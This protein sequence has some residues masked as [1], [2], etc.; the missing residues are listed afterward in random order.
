MEVPEGEDPPEVEEE[1][2]A[3]TG[4]DGDEPVATYGDDDVFA[5]WTTRLYNQTMGAYAVA[6][7]ASNRWP[8]A[9]AAI[10]KSGDKSSCIYIGHGIE[11]A[12]K[13]FNLEAFP[14]IA[15]ESAE[16]DEADDV[17]L[18]AENALLK[19]IDEAKNVA[20]NTPAEEE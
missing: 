12:G 17:A 16:T 8:G 4:I 3:L 20:E 7:A 10:A 13:D 18:E 15:S 6:V 1:G 5:A 9:Y 11:N 19:E 14:P 2:E